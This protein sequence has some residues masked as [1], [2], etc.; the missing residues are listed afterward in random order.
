[1]HATKIWWS[2]FWRILCIG[3]VIDIFLRFFLPAIYQKLDR[4]TFD[5][6]LHL[7]LFNMSSETLVQFSIYSLSL[8]LSS[9]VLTT[10][11][12]KLIV[13]LSYKD[14]KFDLISFGSVKNASWQNV[15]QFSWA[16]IWRSVLLCL[17]V[18]FIINHIL[19]LSQGLRSFI[20]FLAYE[21]VNIIVLKRILT[22]KFK[23]FQPVLCEK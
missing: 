14:F 5:Y 8:L 20:G 9:C 18:Q 4:I 3:I 17:C 19:F 16:W 23:I 13:G 22:K 15:I 11:V 6:G 7:S 1:M 2:W 21:I 10:I 12:V